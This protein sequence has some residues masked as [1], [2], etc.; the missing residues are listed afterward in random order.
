MGRFQAGTV[1]FRNLDTPCQDDALEMEVAR[2]VQ[3]TPA[4]VLD[5]FVQP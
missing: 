4:E 5:I 2:L 3:E 1:W